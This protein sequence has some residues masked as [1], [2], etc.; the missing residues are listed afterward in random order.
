MIYIIINIANGRL[1]KDIGIE[2]ATCKNSTVVD[3]C[4][5]SH[6]LFLYVSNFEFL[7]FDPLLSGVH[8]GIAVEF[9]SKP[10]RQI[11]FFLV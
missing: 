7:P 6:E 4:I 11:S 5:I 9:I 8:S 2:A 10:L 1:F 3:Y